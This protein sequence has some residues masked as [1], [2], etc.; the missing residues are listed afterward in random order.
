MV[1]R[2]SMALDASAARHSSVGVRASISRGEG[3]MLAALMLPKVKTGRSASLAKRRSAIPLT[4][5]AQA[6]T[7]AKA[8]AAGSA[9]AQPANAAKV[10][11]P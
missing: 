9:S 5:R 3:T 7:A 1:S 2:S 8:R 4:G 11:H 6:P 10:N